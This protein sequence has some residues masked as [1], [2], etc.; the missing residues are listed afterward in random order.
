MFHV[1]YRAVVSQADLI[2]QSP[3]EKPVEGQPIGN[4]KM[5]TMVWTT[6]NAINFQI[7]RSDVFAVNKVHEGAQFGPADYC[8]G[9]ASITVDL[10]SEEFCGEA[11][12]QRLSLYDAEVLITGVGVSVRCFISAIS[13]VLVLELD[14]QRQEPKPIRLTVSMWREPEVKT[15]ENKARYKFDEHQNAVVV[16]QRFEEG[17][18]HCSSAVAAKVASLLRCLGVEPP[19]EQDDATGDSGTQVETPDDRARTIAVPARKS[20]TTIL[21]S[22]AASMSP[23]EDVGSE[24]IKVLKEASGQPYDI[25]RQEHARW[26]ADFWSRTFVH[27]E[28]KDGIGEFMARVRN[29]HLYNMASTSRGALPPKWNGSLFITEGD[30][31]RW[32]SQFWVWTTEMLYFPLFAAHA[33]DLTEP[34]F[35][36]YLK[37]LPDCEK[38]AQQRWGIEGA[39]FPETTPFDGPTIL[40][41]DV[42]REFQDVLLGRK[43]HTELSERAYA[44]CQFDSHLRASTN[45]NEG[46]YTWISHVVSSG[47]ELAIQAWWRYRYTGDVE[48]LRTHAYPLL[49]G[50]VEFYRHLVKKGDDGRYHIHGTNVHEDFW[51]VKDS[52]MDLAAIRGTAPLAIRAAEML[53]VDAELRS[54]WKELLHNLAPYPMGNEEESKALTGSVLSD[55]VWAAGHLE[56]VDGQHN[57]EDV[58][59]TPV[60]PFEDWT[61]ETRDPTTDKIVQ[62]AIELAHWLPAIF[63][64]AKIGTA[65]RTPIVWSRAGRGDKLPAILASYYAAFTP[66]VNGFSLFEGPQAHS[67]EHLGCISTALQEALLQSLSPHPGQPEVLSVCPARN[68]SGSSWPQE[69]DA[70]FRLLA[71]GGFLVTAAVSNGEVEFIEIESRLGESCRLRNPW[72]EPCLISEVGGASQELDG[73]ILC[74]DTKQGKHYRVL[75]KGKP[76]PTLRNI[77]PSP[78]TEATSYELVSN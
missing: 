8:G 23:H 25:L 36:M 6:P 16:V 66:L 52:I 12:E 48:W 51:G 29:L 47:S 73:D 50:T 42:A 60:F 20:R 77:S 67:V 30:N 22:S 44:L 41:D 10:G 13:D 5:G 27:I 18:Y 7:N 68:D 72:G 54:K 76:Q 58:W 39:F 69:W 61:L 34:Y 9:C 49:R 53:E 31:R 3:A 65:I 56:D 35:S 21:I 4:G 40:P 26:W 28:S 43:E 55:D 46:R 15:G 63:N 32:G 75:P 57:P 78:V 45:P 33:I 37:H 11:F 59:L 38:A 71:R 24:A 74:F 19:N 64:G 70:S 62:K 2:Y 17:D 14:D 1:N